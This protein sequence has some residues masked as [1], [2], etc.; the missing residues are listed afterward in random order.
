MSLMLMTWVVIMI[1]VFSDTEI[2]SGESLTELPI[3]WSDVPRGWGAAVAAGDAE[4]QGLAHQ[5]R[6][7]LPV[8]TPV[9][10]HWHPPGSGALH[11]RAHDITR[12]RYVANQH[13]VEVTESVYREPYPSVLSAWH[14]A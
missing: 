6:V 12:T 14:P 13:Q 8:L 1:R 7:W 11:V 2:L 4:G 9:T 5:N 10:A 3:G